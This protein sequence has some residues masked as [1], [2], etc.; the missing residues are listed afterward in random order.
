MKIQQEVFDLLK[1]DHAYGTAG[2]TDE[3]I[4]DLA[5]FVTEGLIDTDSM[6]DAN[7]AFIGDVATGQTLYDSGIGT[8]ISC[9]LCHGQLGLS[10]PPGH[11]EFNDYVGL[12][13]NKN[14]WEFQH[15]V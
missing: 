13:S 1:T 7:G 11:S 12:I 4:W 14:P 10:P 6:I 15:K 5:S 9:S 2:L 8:N 3:D